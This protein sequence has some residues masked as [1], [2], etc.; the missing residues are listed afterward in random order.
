MILNFRVYVYNIYIYTQTCYCVQFN[1]ALNV[2][3][4]IPNE[5]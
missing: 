1:T 2:Q 3:Y 4:L 5:N